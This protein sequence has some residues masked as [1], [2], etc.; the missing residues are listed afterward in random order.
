M[1][2]IN[3]FTTGA[4]GGGGIFFFDRV[5]ILFHQYNNTNITYQQ[6]YSCLR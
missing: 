6:F 4:F 1:I 3:I 2:Y 5:A